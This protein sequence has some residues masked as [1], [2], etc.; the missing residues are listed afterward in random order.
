MGDVAEVIQWVVVVY[1]LI[2]RVVDVSQE[3]R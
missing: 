3:K 1:L 2:A